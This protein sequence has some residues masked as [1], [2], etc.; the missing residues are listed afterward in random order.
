M[1]K[2]SW[3][4]VI[5]G[6]CMYM[7]SWEVVIK[8]PCMYMVS[9]EVV[10]KGPCM[11]MVSWKVVIKGPCMYKVSW[12]DVDYHRHLAQHK[13]SR[14]RSTLNAEILCRNISPRLSLEGA[15]LVLNA[16]GYFRLRLS[17]LIHQLAGKV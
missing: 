6:P 14:P 10:I 13:N 11:Y 17:E 2:V 1:Y 15:G 4:V 5:K 16:Y 8:G 12:A 7:V 9:W 3:E